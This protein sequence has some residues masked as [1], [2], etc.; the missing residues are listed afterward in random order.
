MVPKCHSELIQ[1]YEQWTGLSCKSTNITLIFLVKKKIIK[2]L[3]IESTRKGEMNQSTFPHIMKAIGGDLS[4]SIDCYCCFRFL[5]SHCNKVIKALMLFTQTNHPLCHHVLQDTPIW[6]K[7]YETIE[8]LCQSAH[9]IH[10][11]SRDTKH[12]FLKKTYEFKGKVPM[13]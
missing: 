4:M 1:K 11:T 5:R 10:F 7:S 13:E 8:I 2:L 12:I 6:R 9:Q 3:D